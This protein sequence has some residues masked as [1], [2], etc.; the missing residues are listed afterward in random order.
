[1]GTRTSNGSRIALTAARSGAQRPRSYD[2]VEGPTLADVSALHL[3]LA[4]TQ[5]R[6]D[7][8]LLQIEK[9]RR[10]DASYEQQ[11]ALLKD[12]LATARRFAYHDELTGLPNRHLLLDRF[13]QATA[14]AARHDKHV[15]LLFLD[16]DRFKEIN[17]TLG[18]SAGDRLLQQVAVRL[19]QG[20]RASDTACRYG[21]DE[22][23]V[24]LTDLSDKAG[25]LIVANNLRAHLETP[26]VIDRASVAIT[27]SLGI[28]V[29]PDDARGYGDLIQG[30]DLAMYRHKA[31]HPPA[32]RI[33]DAGPQGGL[34]IAVLG[35]Q[36]GCKP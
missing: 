9:M 19:F 10:L 31:R 36:D 6:F 8:A 27:V 3:V 30:S 11:L 15:G 24:L 34:A 29:Y 21:G 33:L 16:L 18:H 5:R 13:K 28:A 32:P 12:S 35:V 14:L 1:M 26:Y 23:V 2:V 22:F 7:A 4:A 20:I 17:S 25:A